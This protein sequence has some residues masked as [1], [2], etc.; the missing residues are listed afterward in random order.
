MRTANSREKPIWPNLNEER[1]DSDMMTSESEKEE[2]KQI[3]TTGQSIFD[4]ISDSENLV[5]VKP[6]ENTLTNQNVVFD[7]GNI[8]DP[9]TH[10]EV[11][12]INSADTPPQ[13]DTHVEEKHATEPEM[14]LRWPSLEYGA[15]H[16]QIIVNGYDMDIMSMK[17]KRRKRVEPQEET[18][19]YKPTDPARFEQHQ[20]PIDNTQFGQ[21]HDTQG[22]PLLYKPTDPAR[23]EQHQQPVDNTQFGQ[24]HEP[25]L[26]RSSKEALTVDRRIINSRFEQHDRITTN[27]PPPNIREHKGYIMTSCRNRYD[28]LKS[29]TIN[30]HSKHKERYDDTTTQRRKEIKVE[31]QRTQQL[32]N[33]PG[34]LP[35]RHHRDQTNRKHKA[36]KRK[37]LRTTSPP[38]DEN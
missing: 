38:C 32:K 25:P 2:D 28:K 18:L 23:F 30:P 36:H 26:S 3:E 24:Y 35:T 1:N 10:K 29:D 5:E 12:R 37:R 4:V 13:D 14:T 15:E 8:E 9:I 19:M 6:R 22:K 34:D 16:F 27:R 31:G 21:H 20:Q 11:A 7:S 33:K 17:P